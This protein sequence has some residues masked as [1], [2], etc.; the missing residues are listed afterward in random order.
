MRSLF[1]FLPVA[2]CESRSPLR[3]FRF[4]PLYDDLPGLPLFSHHKQQLCRIENNQNLFST[5]K[6]KE[7]EPR[8]IKSALSSSRAQSAHLLLDMAVYTWDIVSNNFVLIFTG[9]KK[10]NPTRTEGK[11]PIYPSL[12]YDAGTTR[13]EQGERQ[14]RSSC[15][16]LQRWCSESSLTF[17]STEESLSDEELGHRVRLEPDRYLILCGDNSSPSEL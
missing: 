3:L 11:P 4:Q 17:F 16:D 6:S 15:Q 10:Q 5:R 1:P 14:E 9:R 13:V 8:H 2:T 12:M 7:L